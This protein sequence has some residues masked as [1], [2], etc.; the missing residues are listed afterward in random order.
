M[1]FSRFL[2]VKHIVR[3]VVEARKSETS[4]F[5]C[6]SLL[7][8][9]TVLNDKVSCQGLLIANI[10][11]CIL[12]KSSDMLNKNSLAVKKCEANQKQHCSYS[13]KQPIAKPLISGKAKKILSLE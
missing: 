7:L 4:C 10:S 12:T 11:L 2:R 3:R 13:Y 6:R 1:Y 5:S 8:S 9:T